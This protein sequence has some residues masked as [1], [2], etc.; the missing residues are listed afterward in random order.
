MLEHSNAFINAIKEVKKELRRAKGVLL[1]CVI[2]V[3]GH[4][5][6]KQCGLGLSCFVLSTPPPCPPRVEVS[7]LSGVLSVIPRT[8]FGFRFL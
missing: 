6:A 4:I 7:P 8:P 3:I 2:Q 1:A 5:T